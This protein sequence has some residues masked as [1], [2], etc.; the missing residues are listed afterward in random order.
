MENLDPGWGDDPD[1][2]VGLMRVDSGD[3]LGHDVLLLD[4]YD[5]SGGLGMAGELRHIR[6]EFG[7]RL[8]SS[9]K[10]SCRS[11]AER[12]TS[13]NRHRATC[14]VESLLSE[15]PDRN[16]LDASI[17]GLTMTL[18]VFVST[19]SRVTPFHDLSCSR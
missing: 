10:R 6:V 3:W 15:G 19:L 11:L 1:G 8:L 5:V 12:D 16:P 2:E 18:G 13:Y 17:G 7:D 14:L 9:Q 4:Q